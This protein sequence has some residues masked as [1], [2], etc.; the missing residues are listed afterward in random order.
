MMDTTRPTSLR[1]Y[2]TLYWRIGFGFLALIVGLLVLQSL[3]FSYIVSRSRDTLPGGSPNRFAALV[4]ADVSSDL[5]QDPALDVQRYVREEYGAIV[6]PVFVVMKDGRIAG[7]ATESLPDTIVKAAAFSLGGIEGMAVPLAE[8]ITGP[9]VVMV[10]IK[11]GAT[12]RGLVVVPP[13]RA[14]GG[15]FG[16]AGRLLSVPGLIVLLLATGIVAAL[17]VAPA[18]RRLSDLETATARLGAGD[19][20]ARAS[21]DGGDEVARLARSFNR[22]AV[23][24]AARDEALRTSDRLRRQMLADV[25]HELKTPLTSMRGYLE[26]I[27]MLGGSLDPDTRERYIDTVE[28]ETLRLERIVKDLL[29]LARYENGVTRIEPRVFAI[30][31][32]FERV[33]NRHEREAISRHVQLRRQIAPAAD[34]VVGDPDRIEQVI[35]NLVANAL[36]HTPE[37]GSVDMRATADRHSFVLTVTDSGD[38]IPAEHLPHVFE[39]FYK[40]DEARSNGSGGSGLGLSI[41]KAVVDQHGGTIGVH[42]AP[43]E[44]VFTITLPLQSA[45]ANL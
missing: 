13:R 4:A 41:A 32:V 23:E 27:R 34:Q 22:M 43:G 11:V 39:R 12:V 31:R 42:S 19:L 5:A 6:S 3:L 28:Q 8:D 2:R 15:P 16:D 21:E 24:L 25:S 30:D 14:F 17:I 33:C 1:W 40:V 38:G 29:D 26:T 20:S 10:P 37:G 36:R 18:R 44:T 35:D 45:S 9:P 7:N